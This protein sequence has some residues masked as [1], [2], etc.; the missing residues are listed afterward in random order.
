MSYPAS[1]KLE[2]IRTVEGSHLPLIQTLKILGIPRS[3]YYDWCARW[4]DGGIDALADR[5]PRHRSFWNRI[6]DE[7]RGDL[8]DFALE[9]EDLTP[10]DL[11]IKYTDEKRYFIS[12]TSVHRILSAEDLI[13]SP[14]HA[15]IRAADEFHDKASRPN[16]PWKT[17]FTYLKVN[18]CGGFYLSSI[19]DDCSR[20]IIAWKLCT[21]IKAS[22]V[23]DTLEL[24]L[25]ASGCDQATVI[26]K[27]RLH[28]DNGSSR[29]AADLADRLDD[30]GMDH[31]SS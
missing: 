5:S 13:T 24:A 27:P 9:H 25:E 12:E 17:E 21:R 30:K 8:V 15:V 29:V 16:E 10:R 18:G 28:S 4:S 7:V 19:L 1:E 3:T 23:T 31:L 11:A 26:Q 6:P 20:Y 2:I 14:A 22:D